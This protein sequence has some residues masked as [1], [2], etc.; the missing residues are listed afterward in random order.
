M[1]MQIDFVLHI[2]AHFNF[3]EFAKRLQCIIFMI[4]ECYYKKIV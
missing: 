4:I 2:Y 1:Q 3:G